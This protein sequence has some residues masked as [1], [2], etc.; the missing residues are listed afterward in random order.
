MSPEKKEGKL[1]GGKAAWIYIYTVHIHTTRVID[2][3]KTRNWEAGT[4][5][6]GARR[7]QKKKKNTKRDESEEKKKYI[8]P[9]NRG[10][11]GT[12]NSR[13][14]PSRQFDVHSVKYVAGTVTA[15]LNTQHHGSRTDS[16][17]PYPFFCCFCLHFQAS[18]FCCAF[19]VGVLH[20][21]VGQVASI[22]WPFT[23]QSILI[24]FF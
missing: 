14:A 11:V 23:T 24:V 15:A 16:H 6:V 12:W 5:R 2:A 4:I 17:L 18:P 7:P 21:G 19:L 1:V 13:R 3:S 10:G 8:V 22:Y 20:G 9:A